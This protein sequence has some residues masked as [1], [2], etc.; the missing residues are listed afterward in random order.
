ML[1]QR[2]STLS[3]TD[4]PATELDCKWSFSRIAAISGVILVTCRRALFHENR[5]LDH[6]DES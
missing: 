5:I 6:P 4:I 1:R 2:N 3:Y